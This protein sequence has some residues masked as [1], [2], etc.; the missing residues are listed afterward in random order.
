M[1]GVST[2]AGH[3]DQAPQGT[4]LLAADLTDHQ[5]AAA[6]VLTSVDTLV[7][8]ALSDDEDEAFAAALDS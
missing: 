7:I 4:A 3:D 1:V 2:A 8:E 5:L 6:P